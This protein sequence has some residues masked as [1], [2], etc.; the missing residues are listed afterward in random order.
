[1]KILKITMSIL[2][3]T[4]FFICS[5]TIVHGH[6]YVI[7]ESPTP[8]S[9]LES[10]PPEIT[11]TFNSKVNK[12]FSLTLSNEQQEVKFN[13]KKISSDQ[14][15]ISIQLPP[16]DAGVYT[17][18]YY[19]ISSNDGHPIQGSYQFRINT[20]PA[21]EN[22]VNPAPTQNDFAPEV[23]PTPPEKNASEIVIYIMK[24]IYYLG[25]VT[26]IGW[27]IWNRFIKHDHVKS[28]Y[29]QIG[30]I[31]QMLHFVGFLSVI[32]VQQNIFTLNGLSVG[33]NSPFAT[34]FNF[35]TYIAL[36]MSLFGFIFLFRRVW[37]DIAW[38]VVIVL[39]KSLT[40]HAFEFEPTYLLV[41]SDSIH[42][43]AASLWASGLVIFVVFW[44]KQKL[45][46]KHFLPL[47]S[48]V[49]FYSI[50]ILA[51]TGIFITVMYIPIS[52]LFLTT[53]GLLLFTKTILVVF[54]IL[55]ATIIRSKMKKNKADLARWVTIDFL[56]MVF[57]LIIV[58]I[59][60]YVNP[61]P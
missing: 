26:L 31:L 23:K 47:F 27:I 11:L 49:A 50:C 20:P 17:V 24:A 30:T 18:K 9:M 57:I 52:N 14:K 60:T 36:F 46:A 28:K 56:F 61:L 48:K 4:L 39:T 40:G 13:S 37:F 35:L 12:D 10:S 45:F 1:M 41:I 29:L 6:S 38:I 53:W 55:T 34:T 59:F 54:V 15:Q 7:E 25:L 3:A 43:I 58:S 16:L 51:G 19:V 42:L 8:N 5:H 22:E 44:R 21:P 33:F 32:L 2:F